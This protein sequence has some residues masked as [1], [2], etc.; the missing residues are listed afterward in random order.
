MQDDTSACM[1]RLPFKAVATIEILNS[2]TFCGFF[3][4]PMAWVVFGSAIFDFFR[5]G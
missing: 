1:D 2:I 3:M 5:N 4:L